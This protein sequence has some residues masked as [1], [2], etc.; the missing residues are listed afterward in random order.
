METSEF[1]QL[2]NPA[3]KETEMLKI[4]LSGPAGCGKDW[5]FDRLRE[6][7][8]ERFQGPEA[9]WRR[10]AFA[11]LLYAMLAVMTGLT[12]Q[13]LQWIKAGNSVD[14]TVRR[15]LPGELSQLPSET[16]SLKTRELL[17][18]A[19]T[20]LAR[21]TWADSVWVHRLLLEL[22]KIDPKSCGAVVVTDVR[23]RN[24][25][26]A[27]RR[28]GF[29]M[30]DIQAPL[31][32]HRIQ[33]GNPRYDHPSERDLDEYRSKGLFDLTLLNDRTRLPSYFCDSILDAA[34]ANPSHPEDTNFATLKY[35]T[36]DKLG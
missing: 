25:F 31:Q 5:I 33:P 22:E 34:R 6:I 32:F 28:A 24:E 16:L 30:V 7:A 1:P 29:L 36:G 4:A 21:K 35:I 17:Q 15:R 27:L 3:T 23:F 13:E 9:E 11:D 20:E 26:D 8:R 12:P 18:K 19:G 10:L 14:E 2:S